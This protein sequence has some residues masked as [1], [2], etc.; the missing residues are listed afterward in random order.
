MPDK[1]EIELLKLKNGMS[2][3]QRNDMAEIIQNELKRREDINLKNARSSLMTSKSSIKPSKLSNTLSHEDL[4]DIYS[5]TDK[6]IQKL[7]VQSLERRLEEAKREVLKLGSVGASK[8]KNKSIKNDISFNF[9]LKNKLPML[10]LIL[11][12]FVLGGLR[13]SND[14]EFLLNF[15]SQ[16]PAMQTSARASLGSDSVADTNLKSTLIGDHALDAEQNSIEYGN[17]NLSSSISPIEKGLLLQLDNRRVEL[18]KRKQIL[19]QKEGEIQQQA[20]LVSEKVAELKSLITKL[21]TIR[22]EKDHKYNAR[23]EQLASVYSAMTPQESA[24][25]IAKL[26]NDIGLALLERMPGK[27]MAQILGVMDQNRALELTKHLTDKKKL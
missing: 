2:E 10:M 21:S 9:S 15:Q 20:Q 5:N 7:R 13:Y 8:K 27:R 26:D 4:S 14:N 18:E 6:D 1:D 23:M 12:L 16:K 19:D 11:V 25:L 17:K 24:N 22:K 3:Q